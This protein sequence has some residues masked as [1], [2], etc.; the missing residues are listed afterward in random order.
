MN[1]IHAAFLGRAFKSGQQ[2]LGDLGR[3]HLPWRVRKAAPLGGH[4]A[5]PE[6]VPADALPAGHIGDRLDPLALKQGPQ[7]L[8]LAQR[9]GVE[10]TA[11]SAV[12]G[13]DDYGRPRRARVRPGQ[14]VIDLSRP[15]DNRLDRPGELPGVGHGRVQPLLRLND[16][17][18]RD[19]LLGARDLGGGLDTLD[20]PPYCAKLGSNAV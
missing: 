11:E 15:A 8:R 2:S 16:P 17:R 20:P 4:L 7:A 18:G 19:Q 13:E 14:R 3:V 9:I 5:A 6:P 1:L 12:A 10:A